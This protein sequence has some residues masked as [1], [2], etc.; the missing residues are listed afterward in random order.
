MA[1]RMRDYL[2]P[3]F[4]PILDRHGV[5][6]AYES[7]MRLRGDSSGTA[8][9][10]PRLERSRLINVADRSMIEQIGNLSCQSTYRGNLRFNINIS[11]VSID[12]DPRSLVAKLGEVRPL[13]RGLTVELPLLAVQHNYERLL[14][15]AHL[16]KFHRIHIAL[17]S[18]EL[19]MA[20]TSRRFLETLRPAYIKI[21]C[22]YLMELRGT[23]Q[24]PEL[25]KAIEMA[26]TVGTH[27]VVKNIE[28]DEGH[29]AATL[30][31]ARFFQGRY[32]APESATVPPPTPD[33]RVRLRSRGSRIAE[34][35]RLARVI[36]PVRRLLGNR[37]EE[38]A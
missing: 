33:Q 18:A 16:C 23:P 9:F 35:G 32:F 4:Q 36:G 27:T 28:S 2:I 30:A 8:R 29:K 15:F 5:I 37:G 38:A 11:A 20:F 3:N 26:S 22:R 6:H 34:G 31:G 12:S 10:I 21:D 24:F 25:L 1:S 7:F 17:E 19:G 14:E 13:T